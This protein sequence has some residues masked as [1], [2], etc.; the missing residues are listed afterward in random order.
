M[1]GVCTSVWP[2]YAV[3]A[4]GFL[5]AFMFYRIGRFDEKQAQERLKKD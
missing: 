5:G 2:L 4:Y 1:A 3:L